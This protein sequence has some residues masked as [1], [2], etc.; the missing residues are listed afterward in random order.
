[1]PG[2]NRPKSVAQFD[3]SYPIPRLFEIYTGKSLLSNNIQL[4]NMQ[5]KNKWVNNK[6]IIDKILGDFKKSDDQVFYLFDNDMS[7]EIGKAVMTEN[8]FFVGNQDIEDA[9]DNKI[10]V[11]NLNHY[12][13]GV[14]E[15]NVEE[16]QSWKELVPLEAK[17]NDH[18]K[19]YPILNRKIKDKLKNLGGD[20]DQL[21]RI[22]SKGIE[23]A[24][25]LLLNIN[26]LDDIPFEIR[27]AFDKVLE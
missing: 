18:E 1:M 12:Y 20:I 5:G 13:N 27:E 25:F 22:P 26:E 16:V 14:L 9:I 17:C 7:F 4:I 2:T 3:P 10:W 21:K 19:F 8:M 11:S 24:D 6:K 23:S 15:F